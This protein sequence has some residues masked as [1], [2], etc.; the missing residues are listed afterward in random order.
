MADFLENPTHN[1]ELIVEYQ[2]EFVNIYNQELAKNGNQEYYPLKLRK[3][4]LETAYSRIERFQ[5]DY[6]EKVKAKILKEINEQKKEKF[7]E[8]KRQ[9]K[10]SK[11]VSNGNKPM[12][13]QEEQLALIRKYR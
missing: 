5:P 10:I 7:D 1:E 13:Y 6:E 3:K 9:Q 4:A 2:Q 11:P 8:A 12:T